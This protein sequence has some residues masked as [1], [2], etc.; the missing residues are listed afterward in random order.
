MAV[1][2][3]NLKNLLSQ[4]QGIVDLEENYIPQ[5]SASQV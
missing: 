5:L 1:I 4:E 2:M 3:C